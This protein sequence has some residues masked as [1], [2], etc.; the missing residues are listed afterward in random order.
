[1]TMGTT[2]GAVAAAAAVVAALPWWIFAAGGAANERPMQVV[3]LPVPLAEVGAPLDIY[4]PA[5]NG[6]TLVAQDNGVVR[7]FYRLYQPGETPSGHEGS[8]AILYEDRS[9]DGG[10]TWTIGRQLMNTGAGSRDDTAHIN[11]YTGETYLFYTRRAGTFLKRSTKG[12]S[13]WQPDIKVPFPCVWD[14]F[15]FSWL[16]AVEAS[17]FHRLVVVTTIGSEDAN[18]AP[19]VGTAS[20]YSDDDGRTWSG[21]SNL[22]TT[23]P[24]PG[25]WN[26]PS[27]SGQVVELADGR[28]WMLT[29]SSQDHLWEA[30]STDR[31]KSWVDGRASRFVGVFSN[32]RLERIPDGRLMIVWL[33]NMPY[34]GITD[35]GSF[36]N[37]ARDVIHAAVSADEGKTWRGFREVFLD[38]NRHEL[39]FSPP[40]PAFDAGVHHPK[41]AV[42]PGGR[43]VVMSGQDDDMVLWGSP[44][45]RAVIFSLDWLAERGRQSDFSNGLADWSTQRLSKLRWRPTN[46]YARVPGARITAHPTEPF[47]Q[48]L[49]VGRGR[50]GWVLNEQDGAV[51]NFP[52]GLRGTLQTQV[53]L[54]PGFKGGAI[55]LTDAYYSPTDNAGEADAPFVLEI[56]PTGRVGD[57]T[58]LPD[59]WYDL[60]LTWDG[61]ADVATHA[62]TVTI[63]GA[64]TELRLPLRRASVNGISYVRFR[65]TA[66]TEDLSGYLVSHVKA[67]VF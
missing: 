22:V 42:L 34:S 8:G 37:T 9:D 49:H 2:I 18:K 25:R 40:P 26:N 44:H 38:R 31:G 50:A 21:P 43:A 47:R 20:S 45:R 5:T 52:A 58:L 4:S 57:I 63:A 28:L 11:P 23:A 39:V 29:R 61:T 33:N 65:S 6:G 14:R 66:P 7:F 48:V 60:V 27:A 67:S 36:H 17:G 51:W 56:P 64:S 24:Y 10:Y 15:G 35:E 1:M 54:R 59:T 13:A 32:V 19:V 16:R 12:G 41:F 53:L 55:A 46:Y 3:R 30:W 62:C